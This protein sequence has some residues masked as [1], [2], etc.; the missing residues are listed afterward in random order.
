MEDVVVQV[1]KWLELGWTEVDESLVEEADFVE[2]KNLE[3]V[4]N[5]T[6]VLAEHLEGER[7]HWVEE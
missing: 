4:L 3:Q 6:L 2:S 1:L 7:M 5:W